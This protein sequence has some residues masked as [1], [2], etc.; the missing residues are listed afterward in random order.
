MGKIVTLSMIKMS[1]DY[2]SSLKKTFQRYFQFSVAYQREKLF[3]K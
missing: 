3:K 2:F 1:V